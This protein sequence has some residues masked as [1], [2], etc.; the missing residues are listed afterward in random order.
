M[1]GRFNA[2][3]LI[4][5]SNANLHALICIYVKTCSVRGLEGSVHS[6]QTSIWKKFFERYRFCYWMFMALFWVKKKTRSGL[7]LELKP[8]SVLLCVSSVPASCVHIWFVSCPC[9]MSLWVNSCP[10]VFVSLSVIN[11]CILVH[12]CSVWFRLVYL[13]LLSVSCLSVLPWCPH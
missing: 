3:M 2:N 9:L 13:L 1:N 5:C 7:L 4:L 10:A 11:L 6:F 12:A 8:V